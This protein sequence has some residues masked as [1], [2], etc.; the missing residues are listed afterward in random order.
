MSGTEF[1]FQICIRI[2]LS[3]L[4]FVQVTRIPAVEAYTVATDPMGVPR[5]Y[6]AYNGD[7]MKGRSFLMS[8]VE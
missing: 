2:C 6:Q 5:F 1:L 8:L 3:R 4:N 7:R